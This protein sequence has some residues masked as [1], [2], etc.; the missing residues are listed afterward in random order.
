[1]AKTATVYVR[2]E[3]ELKEQ[4]EAIL[5]ELGISG[6]D[7]VG[8]FYR[9]VIRERGMPFAMKLG[10]RRPLEV[11]SLSKEEFDAALQKGIDDITSG[12]VMSA[13]EVENHFRMR[14]AACLTR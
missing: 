3:P 7:G 4:A 2:I 9:A 5:A 14:S 1:M 10:I 13:D 8:M 11:S 12:Q 6:S